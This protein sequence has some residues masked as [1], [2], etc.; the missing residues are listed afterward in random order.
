MEEKDEK[1]VEEQL[2]K[3]K[4]SVFGDPVCSIEW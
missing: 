2:K 4:F 1:K 3:K